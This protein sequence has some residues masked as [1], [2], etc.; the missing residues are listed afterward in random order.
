[1]REALRQR[2][3]DPF[4]PLPTLPRLRRAG[5]GAV[6]TARLSTAE[7]GG[8]NGDA[9]PDGTRGRRSGPIVLADIDCAQFQTEDWKY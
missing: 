5:R 6:Q 4:A 2:S 7:F 8:I 1:M 3:G 9:G